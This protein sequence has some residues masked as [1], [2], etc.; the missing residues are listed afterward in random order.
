MGLNRSFAEDKAL[1]SLIL[2]PPAAALL[3]RQGFG[4]ETFESL[5]S[6]FSQTILFAY[7][8]L[9]TKTTIKAIGGRDVTTISIVDKTWIP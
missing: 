9:F 6:H 5:A 4:A 1:F 2:R 3:V 7:L 8:L